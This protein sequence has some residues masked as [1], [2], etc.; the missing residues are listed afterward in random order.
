MFKLPN[1]FHT[2]LM[3]CTPFVSHHFVYL[4]PYIVLYSFASFVCVIISMQF[5]A[6]NQIQMVIYGHTSYPKRSWLHNTLRFLYTSTVLWSNCGLRES[7]WRE[8]TGY[9]R[10]SPAESGR[11]ACSSVIMRIKRSTATNCITFFDDNAL[12]FC[13]PR[14]QSHIRGNLPY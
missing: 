11:T 12:N 3:N 14:W 10:A 13:A 6:Q 1:A 4:H 5:D 9:T 7:L 2:I 8:S